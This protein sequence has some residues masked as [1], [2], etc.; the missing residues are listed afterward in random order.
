MPSLAMSWRT[1]KPD[2]RPPKSVPGRQNAIAA[3][4]RLLGR[5]A[6]IFIFYLYFN[7]TLAETR[8]F[9]PPVPISEY[10]DLANRRLQPLGH[11]SVGFERIGAVAVHCKTS[12]GCART[13]P[14]L[15]R[16]GVRSTPASRRRLRHRILPCDFKEWVP[17][18]CAATAF[19]HRATRRRSGVGSGRWRC[20]PQLR[21]SPARCRCCREQ[22]AV[23]DQ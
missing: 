16:L 10:N 14:L 4:G 9:E 1:S 17:T 3:L 19:P 7:L 20:R 21:P 12:R 11:V 6:K 5:V 22:P 8:G 13:A 15:E 23:D 18:C 2:N